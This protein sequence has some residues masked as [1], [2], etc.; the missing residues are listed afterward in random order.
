MCL[1]VFKFVS[2]TLMSVDN[3]D[4]DRNGIPE[5]YRSCVACRVLYRS[6][7]WPTACHPLP[8]S[9]TTLLLQ[10]LQATRL[11]SRTTLDC[12]SGLRGWAKQNI[13]L[14]KQETAL[15]AVFLNPIFVKPSIIH[16]FFCN[17][18]LVMFI[19]SVQECAECDAAIDEHRKQ[20]DDYRTQKG[21]LLELQKK[22][23]HPIMVGVIDLS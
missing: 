18:Y 20:V 6:S 7:E 4:T 9:T 3:I 11:Q 1:E 10:L 19:K 8:P 23:S 14:T 21:R 16:L 22:I 12:R 13:T 17:L 5:M 15:I 2:L